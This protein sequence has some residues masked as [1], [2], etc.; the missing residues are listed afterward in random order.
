VT[1]LGVL[2]PSV[3]SAA[4]IP[5]AAGGSDLVPAL[6]IAG[7]GG[8]VIILIMVAVPAG[9]RSGETAAPASASETRVQPTFRAY[10]I[11]SPSFGDSTP[12]PESVAAAVEAAPVADEVQPAAEEPRTATV[13]PAPIAEEPQPTAA[14]AERPTEEPQPTATEADETPSEAEPD[15]GPVSEPL[16]SSWPNPTL[17]RAAQPLG[18]G[19]VGED[20]GHGPPARDRRRDVRMSAV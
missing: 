19:P 5:T 13:D 2:F 9:R 1:A 15:T 3:A 12:P 17:P 20:I 6:V 14:E 11:S 8:L 18:S 4:A 7:A 16:T 10:P